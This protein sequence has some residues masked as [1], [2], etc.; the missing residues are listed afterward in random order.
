M[1]AFITYVRE[2]LEEL[3][4]VQW[5]TQQ[6]AIRLTTIVVIFIAVNAVFFGFVDAAFTQIIRWTLRA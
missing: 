6:Q 5:P 4:L 3:R 1:N 2:S